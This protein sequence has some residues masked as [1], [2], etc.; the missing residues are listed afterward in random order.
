MGEQKGGKEREGAR[1]QSVSDY[2]RAE[3]HNPNSFDSLQVVREQNKSA[4][5]SGAELPLVLLGVDDKETTRSTGKPRPADDDD[6]MLGA[7]KGRARRAEQS[8]EAPKA[9]DRVEEAAPAQ[10][11]VNRE[12]DL[13]RI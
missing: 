2:F 9:N 3:F 4:Q 8:A 7:A 5:N 12:F 11:Q 6:S 1:I 10:P 13:I